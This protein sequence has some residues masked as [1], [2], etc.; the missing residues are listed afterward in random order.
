M[1]SLA[2][3]SN[4]LAAGNDVYP[5]TSDAMGHM[6]KIQ[7]IAET[8]A[9][10]EIPGWF[11]GWYNGSTV[12]QYYVPLSYYCMVPFYLLTH[13][14]M[15][16]YKISC[17]LMM[18]VGGMGIWTFCYRKIGRGCGLV[19]ILAYCLQPF[20]ADSLYEAGAI[21][22]GMIFALAPW[23]LLA[24]LEFIDKPDR[25]RFFFSV[26]SAVL[27]ILSHAMDAFMICGCTYVCLLLF[28][29]IKKISMRNYLL[30]VLTV[31]LAGVLTAFWSLVGVTGLEN[32]GIPMADSL[33]PGRIL[34]YTAAGAAIATAYM[35]YQFFYSE[36]HA[37]IGK[38]GGMLV[39]AGILVGMNPLERTYRTLTEEQF[40][41]VAEHLT[42]EG[43]YFDKG[44]YTWFGEVDSSETYFPLQYGYQL[45]DG[46]NMEGTPHNYT[47]GNYNIAFSAKK[48][49]YLQKE[50][51]FWNVRN[52]LCAAEYKEFGDFLIQNGFE[53]LDVGREGYEFYVNQAPSCYYLKDN[54]NA[55]LIDRQTGSMGMM[56][57]YLIQGK[58]DS[59][60]EYTFEELKR[61]AFIYICEPDLT[62]E[63]GKNKFE[64]LVTKL[65]NAGIRV[66]IEPKA[67][68][69]F[70]LFD[71]HVV[72]EAIEDVPV[73]SV[74]EACPYESLTQG[75][76]S[77]TQIQ[78]VRS[79][80]GLD[81]TYAQ[82][83]QKNGTICN[84]VL[85]TKKVGNGE[86]LFVGAHMSQYLETVYLKNYGMDALYDVTRRN[87]E[88]IQ[89]FY[90]EMFQKAGVSTDYLPENFE[91]VISQ[92]WDS[93]GGSFTYDAEESGEVI[94]SVTYTPR[95][96]VYLDG[97]EIETKQTEHLLTL[98]LLAGKH[99]V[100]MQYRITLY[101]KIG[102]LCSVTGLVIFILCLLSFEKCF[103]FWQRLN[104]RIRKYLQISTR[105]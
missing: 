33:V 44:R 10:G 9:E 77:N 4:L 48:Y 36:Y 37:V 96:R 45:S 1:C 89:A 95:W 67:S 62:T 17:V 13:N 81:K 87:S 41:G 91:Q 74:T 86:V 23:Y 85:G 70:D 98:D 58:S 75:E 99:T 78:I 90:E 8:L 59:L 15:L 40:A 64:E 49:E 32:P 5:L 18:F 79:L 69:R 68:G 56:F 25:K 27:L 93:Q 84:D 42:E 39:L 61:Y 22:Q 66:V 53:S 92:E 104:D 34:D 3:M 7:Y 29:C 47:I 71:V 73:L 102:Y 83:T 52:V 72:D 57:P 2:A 38:I 28:V 54:R 100:Q 60:T 80:Y 11:P 105:E 76:L 103:A 14:V 101:G 97:E 21:A 19:G 88:K 6:A 63:T 20:L 46:R 30:G 12:T 82:F 65:V 16:T 51:A 26:I 55:L 31:V 24:T 35:F 94:V 43:D 50:L